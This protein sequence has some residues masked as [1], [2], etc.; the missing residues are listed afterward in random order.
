MLQ[1]MCPDSV[2]PPNLGTNVLFCEGNYFGITEALARALVSE[3]PS[4]V[5]C[6]V[7]LLHTDP[8]SADLVVGVLRENG[9]G[10]EVSLRGL[11]TY[12]IKIHSC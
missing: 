12:R 9:F 11:F 5:D 3:I 4:K 10:V 7:Y 6:T 2:T 8:A 1:P